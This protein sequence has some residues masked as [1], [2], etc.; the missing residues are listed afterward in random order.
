MKELMEN[1]IPEIEK[2]ETEDLYKR[3]KEEV[4]SLLSL[5]SD[6]DL[7]KSL[8]VA[9]EQYFDNLNKDTRNV[10]KF[11]IPDFT[12]KLWDVYGDFLDANKERA[13]GGEFREMDTQLR[14]EFMPRFVDTLTSYSIQITNQKSQ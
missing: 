1:A 10:D 4:I 3:A 2:V 6:I 14:T 8:G 5:I 12:Q 11:I 13:R 7:N 9:I